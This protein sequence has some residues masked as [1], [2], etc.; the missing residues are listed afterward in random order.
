MQKNQ[1][2]YEKILLTIAG[3][4]A[5]AVAGFL[6]WTSKSFPDRLVVRQVQQKNDPGHPPIESLNAAMKRLQEKI[7]WVS[8]VIANKPVPLNKS[9]LIVRKGDELFDLQVP[10]PQ[11]R[12]P[13]TNAYLV[14]NDL[15]DIFSPNVGDLDPDADGFTNLEEFNKTNPRDPQDHPPVTDKLFLKQRIAN[16]YILKLNSSSPPFQVQ[17]IKPD[18]KG[19][20][21]VA[22]GDQFGFDKGVKRF[23]AEKFEQKVV[24]DP[25]VGEKD[26]SE[27]TVLDNATTQT[28]VLVRGE[29]KNLAEYMAEFE[30][31]W[32]NIEKRTVK[33]GETFQLPNVATTFKV[34]EVEEDKAVIA[35]VN[36]DGN[37]GTQLTIPR[38]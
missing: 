3:L 35:P 12:P 14:Q 25:K 29:E 6:I 2:N 31:R 16:D 23:K 18:P 7:T 9:I 36:P 37:L 34:L 30:F 21:F 17:R 10:E 8:P 32:K 26:V 19:S 13:M 27:L 38:G 22:P 4:V 15:P 24:A 1:G 33:K 5:I 20:Q 28:F 11:F